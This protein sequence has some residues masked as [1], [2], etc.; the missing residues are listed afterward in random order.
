[1]TLRLLVVEDDAVDLEVLSRALRKTPLAIEV[2]EAD[3]VA[4]ARARL[5]AD[6]FDCVISDLRL[7]DGDGIGLVPLA[8][9]AAFVVLT[10]DYD[11]VA[12]EALTAGA[13]DF[14]VKDRLDPYWLGRSVE[15][16]IERR[17]L[18]VYQRDAEHR[19]RLHSLG[20]LAASVA[21]E[22]NNPVAFVAANLEALWA[23]LGG[24]AG[25]H[26]DEETSHDILAS[27][28]DSR[29]GLDRVSAIVQQLRTFAR[30][31]DEAEPVMRVE[32][33][34]VLG[35]A[36]ALTRTQLTHHARLEQ[37]LELEGI[38]LA[39]RPGLLAQVFTNLFLNAAQAVEE[40]AA[41]RIRVSAR[42][43]DA[44][45]EVRVEDSGPGIAAADRQRALQPFFTTKPSGKGTG[46]GLS[47]AYEIV[48]SHG[49]DLLLEDSPSLGG[50]CARVV[51]PIDT[52]LRVEAEAEA[53]PAAQPSRASLSLL[54]VDDEPALRR[55]YTRLL[56]PH[57]VHACDARSALRWLEAHHA[58][59][60]AIV[61]DVMMPDLNGVELYRAAVQA[62]PALA[63]RFVFTS[64]GVFR[65]DLAAALE[66]LEP[67]ATVL[68]KPTSRDAL[69]AAVAR[70]EKAPTGEADQ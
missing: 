16:A 66:Q 55:A 68:L 57:R 18:Q 31:E 33:A 59:V 46:L 43:V 3:S 45:V 69:L 24:G 12:R 47:V 35:W 65:P 39:G 29:R 52:G 7:P 58:D 54:V 70:L 38:T 41:A 23:L 37:A 22:I 48:S 14:L 64:G 34:E 61:C 51:L 67:A 11:E 4:T 36:L 49:G 19:D 50:L 5:A 60:D 13:Q 44:T 28:A 20:Q 56:R 9:D 17:R 2:T 42:Q 1:M 27:I 6:R 10:G 53:E 40:R 26:L 62:H 8:G 15:Y 25:G 21:H 63:Y 32:V 30:R